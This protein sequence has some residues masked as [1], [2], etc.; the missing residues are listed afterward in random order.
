MAWAQ[1]HVHT[2]PT[3]LTSFVGRDEEIAAIR[4]LLAMP[5]CRLLTL[6]GPGGIGKTR[7]AL[8]T[9]ARLED[10]FADGVVFTALQAV[11]NVDELAG[12]VATTLGLPQTGQQEP[13]V[14]IREYLRDKHL[15]LILDNFEHLVDGADLVTEVL[16]AA[17]RVLCLVTSREALNLQEEWLYPLDGL[18]LP[19]RPVAADLASTGA[20]RLFVER[21][22]RVNRAFSL[23]DEQDAV[24]RICR[25]VEG[26][27]LA[28]ELAATWTKT[29]SCAVIAEEIAQNI[30]LLTTSMRNIPERH[31]SVKA[32]FDQSWQR[33]ADG[34]R[35]VFARLALFQGSFTLD[36]AALVGGA[37]PSILATLVDTSFVRRMPDGRY[38][39]HELLRQYAEERLREAPETFAATMEAH[40]RYYISFLGQRLRAISGGRQ[41]EAIREIAAEIENIR[42][43][44]RRAA[45]QADVEAIQQAVHTLSTFNI[46]RGPYQEGVA[47]LDLAVHSLRSTPPSPL[48]D[49][50]LADVL[51]E[52][53]YFWIRIGRFVEAKTALDES[54]GLYTTGG[55]EP[56]LGTA[57]DPVFGHGILALAQGSYVEAARLGEQAYQRSVAAGH[58]S[59]Q[60]YALYILANAALA[61]GQTDTAQRCIQQAYDLAEGNEDRWFMSYCLNELGNVAC[62]RGAYGEARR[63]YQASYALREEFDDPQ[64]MAVA[65]SLLGKAAL[66]EG[67][68]VEAQAVYARSVAIY[69]EIGDRGGLAEALHGSGRAAGAADDYAQ[70]RAYLHE[71][72]R[73][74][75]GMR[76]APLVLAILVSSAEVVL[77]DGLAETGWEALAFT[78]Q[79]PLS[80]RET[81]DRARRLL[82]RFEARQAPAALAAAT[83]RGEAADL[84]ATVARILAA[85]AALPGS[86]QAGGET[87]GGLDQ[88]PEPE[89]VEL[90][91]ERERTIL[92]LIA[93]GLSNQEIADRL[94]LSLG[95]VKWYTGQIYG[96]LGVQTRIQAVARAR[97]LHLLP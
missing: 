39:L 12:A 21:A 36:A 95:T 23:A 80:D 48:R 20:V 56:P 40:K 61:Q 9:A 54:V 46:I 28:I 63:H 79:H 83:R 73:I 34:E 96:K 15:L 37:S 49:Q 52:L 24:V 88:S 71:A 5:A 70:A 78:A 82:Q 42:A 59:N 3:P 87:G 33:L 4:D 93:E 89:L 62:A 8:E 30:A 81:R 92:A 85:L 19:A 94:I 86:A 68:Y 72:L 27:P 41:V 26:M 43:A 25:L 17:P 2:L 45:A 91:G 10:A 55:F 90:L 44:W 51:R 50:T 16:E 7:L 97:M 66:L 35:A 74:A 57:T 53:G 11:P 65:L 13:R 32:A 60:S 29:L 1:K 75:A 76:F 84:D 67:K 64:G 77:Q 38:H 18:D 31:R 14:H 47:A 69:R 58:T 6:L 22:Q